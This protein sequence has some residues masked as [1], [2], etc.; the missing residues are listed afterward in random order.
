MTSGEKLPRG[1]GVPRPGAIESGRRTTSMA[2]A[3]IR[4]PADESP[5]FKGGDQAM[6]ARLGP[7]VQRV[8][9]FIKRWRNTGFLQSF[10]NE[11]EQ[12]VLL[13]RQHIGIP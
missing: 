1:R 13:A 10:V 2:R 7:K 8:L 11:H 4:Q 3:L 9:H 5:F 12:F 6:N